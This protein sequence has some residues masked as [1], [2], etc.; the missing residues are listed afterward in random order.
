MMNMEE[1]QQELQ[2]ILEKLEEIQSR[3]DEVLGDYGKPNRE[4][5]EIDED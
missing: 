4:D 5:N 3:I 1:I 2:D